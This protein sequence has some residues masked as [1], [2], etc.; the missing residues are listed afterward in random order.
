[1]EWTMDAVMIGPDQRKIE[2]TGR[3]TISNPVKKDGKDYLTTCTWMERDGKKF[4]EYTKLLTLA[5]LG[6][7]RGV[8]AASPPAR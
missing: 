4:S 6:E 7:A 3:R 2:C 5:E 1:M 8:Y